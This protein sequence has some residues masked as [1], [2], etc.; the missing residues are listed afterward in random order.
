MFKH[1][2]NFWLI[3]E[4]FIFGWKKAA[5]SKRSELQ[6]GS[7]CWALRIH[8]LPPYPSSVPAAPAPMQEYSD[9][10]DMGTALEQVCTLPRLW[11][12]SHN[13]Q[14]FVHWYFWSG[15]TAWGSVVSTL[16]EWLFMPKQCPT[17]GAGDLTLMCSLLLL[18]GTGSLKAQLWTWTWN[19]TPQS[20][21]VTH[22]DTDFHSLLMGLL[23]LVGL[24]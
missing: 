11:S 22:Q 16:L 10:Q 7:G 17:N 13:H 12:C 23:Y 24:M 1:K 2:W 5:K 19:K 3:K 20:L 15:K 14:C 6:Q 4:I 8:L 9:G 18:V 21:W